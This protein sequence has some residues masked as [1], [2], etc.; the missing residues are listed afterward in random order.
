MFIKASLYHCN[1][2][3]TMP[4]GVMLLTIHVYSYTTSSHPFTLVVVM[5]KQREQGITAEKK[6]MAL[7]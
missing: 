7:P 6:E 1:K 5:L 4:N 2:I 3:M